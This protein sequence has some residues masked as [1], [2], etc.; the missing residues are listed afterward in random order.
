M[1]W[2]GS[3]KDNVAA[4]LTTRL[5]KPIETGTTLRVEGKVVK[6]NRKL[7]ITEGRIL[8]SN[9]VPMLT[10]SGKYVPMTDN[11]ASLCEED[12]VSSPDSISPAEFLDKPSPQA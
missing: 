7:V 12:F 5:K 6:N 3:G 4:E 8:D 10:A 1:N 9:N 2:A 11:Q